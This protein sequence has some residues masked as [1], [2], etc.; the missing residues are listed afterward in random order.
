MKKIL[1]TLVVVFVSLSL[2]AQQPETQILHN[3]FSDYV[4]F[5]KNHEFKFKKPQIERK[6]GNV[7]I[8]ISEMQFDRMNRMRMGGRF[9]RPGFQY[10][11]FRRPQL[12]NRCKRK[13]RHHKFIGQFELVIVP[14]AQGGKISLPVVI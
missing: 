8:T 2:I 3:Q 5:R 7:I 9:G 14:P 1:L 11:N 6:D 4:G 12:C 13:L 10:G